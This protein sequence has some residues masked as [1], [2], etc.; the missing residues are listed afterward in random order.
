MSFLDT[1]KGLLEL[2]LAKDAPLRSSIVLE[3][4]VPQHVLKRIGVMKGM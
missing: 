2:E 3:I 1:S 4:S